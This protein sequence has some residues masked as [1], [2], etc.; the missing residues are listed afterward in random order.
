[1]QATIKVRFFCAA[2]R[3]FRAFVACCRTERG[4]PLSPFHTTESL[5]NTSALNYPRSMFMEI[6]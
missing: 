4:R 3:L 1:M 2:Y 6:L 5:A